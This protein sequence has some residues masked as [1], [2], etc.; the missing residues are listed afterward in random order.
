MNR[1]LAIK[2]AALGAL[3]AVSVGALSAFADRPVP[4]TYMTYVVFFDFKKSEVTAEALQ[5]VDQ[6][7]ANAIADK[8]ARITITGYTDAAEG[9]DMALSRSRALSVLNELN[10]KGIGADHVGIVAKGTRDP[11]VPTAKG[12][13]EPQNRRVTIDFAR[14]PT[15]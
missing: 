1:G 14:A 4:Q 11:S 10:R 6:A 7:A 13:K 5:I 15:P 3:C 9:D 2:R 8:P 12:V